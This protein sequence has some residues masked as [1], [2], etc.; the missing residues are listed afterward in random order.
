MNMLFTGSDMTVDDR[1]FLMQVVTVMDI[2]S[3]AGFFYPRLIPLQDIN[4]DSDELP[5]FICCTSDNIRDDG[6][7][8]LEIWCSSP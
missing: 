5:S 3:S 8:L 4:V 6:V 1:S 7:Y 2:P